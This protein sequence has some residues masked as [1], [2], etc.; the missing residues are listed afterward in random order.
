[1]SGKTGAQLNTDSVN[2]GVT[3]FARPEDGSWD[4]SDPHHFY[5]ATTANFTG[6]SRLWKLSFADVAAIATGG[7]AAIAVQG[8]P[9]DPSKPNRDQ[10][11]P[12]IMDNITVN[13][14]GQVIIQ[15]DVGGQDYVGGV[16]QYDPASG[17]VVRIAQH[18]PERFAPGAAGFLTRDEESSGVIPV[19]FLGEGK[20]LLDV[21]AH[22]STGDPA[23]VEGGQLL[24]LHIPP[25]KPVR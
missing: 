3:T 23:T 17:N 18:D 10:P 5:F 14:R 25:A 6:V 4:P 9:A 7:T 1:V 15:E 22:Y 24:V 13:S 19:P 16:F 20:Y 12:R 21:Q 2:A 11:G 8:R